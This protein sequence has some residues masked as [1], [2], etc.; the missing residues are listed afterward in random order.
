MKQIL[1]AV[2]LGAPPPYKF[3][4]YPT[5]DIFW[6]HIFPAYG[7]YVDRADDVRE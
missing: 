6:P 3:D 5:P 4:C 2:V 1:V 7:L